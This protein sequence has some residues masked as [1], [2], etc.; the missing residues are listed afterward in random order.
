MTRNNSGMLLDGN[1]ELTIDSTKVRRAGSTVTMAQDYVYGDKATDSF[2]TYFGDFNGDRLV[3]SADLLSF[4]Q[5]YRRSDGGVGYNAALD[6]DNDGVVS[7]LDLLN[8]RQRYRR[9]L[10]FV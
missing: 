3:S 8:F 1:Y 5:T 6:Y 10:A 2:Y 7:S 9:S 4:R